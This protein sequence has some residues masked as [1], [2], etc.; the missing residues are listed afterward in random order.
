MYGSFKRSKFIGDARDF[1]QLFKQSSTV[2]VE[3]EK[4][5]QQRLDEFYEAYR[6]TN[7]HDDR[8]QLQ[9]P[10]MEYVEEIWHPHPRWCGH[11]FE[12]IRCKYYRDVLVARHN[13]TKLFFFIAA[14]TATDERAEN[15]FMRDPKEFSYRTWYTNL[16]SKI[17]TGPELHDLYYELG[18]DLEVA[19]P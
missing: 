11:F 19:S 4:H 13:I 9:F 3:F 15:M 7:V 10:G 16:F 12:R 2:V 6:T 14:S 1:V 5:E 17:P 8:P 18:K